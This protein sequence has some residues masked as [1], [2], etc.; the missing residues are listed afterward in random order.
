MEVPFVT[1]AWTDVRAARHEFDR[2]PFK[3]LDAP[4]GEK[5]QPV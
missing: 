1:G 3:E 5:V 4:K 2:H